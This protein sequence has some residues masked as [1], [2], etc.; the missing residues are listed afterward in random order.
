MCGWLRVAAGAAREGSCANEE[1][2]EGIGGVDR[3]RTRFKA[4]ASMNFPIDGS[5]I[6]FTA[7]PTTAKFSCQD[8]CAHDNDVCYLAYL[9]ICSRVDDVVCLLQDNQIPARPLTSTATTATHKST[10]LFF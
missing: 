3:L 6:G 1:A 9:F 5:S 10:P 2:A 4:P 7:E 8:D